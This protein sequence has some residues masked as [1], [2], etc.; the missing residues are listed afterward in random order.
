MYLL[1]ME[2][3]EKLFQDICVF[4]SVQI[5]NEQKRQCTSKQFIFLDFDA[6]MYVLS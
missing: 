4:Q 1:E 5:Y 6:K 3:G 2:K